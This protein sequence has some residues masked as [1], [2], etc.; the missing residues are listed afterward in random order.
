MIEQLPLFIVV[1][2]IGAFF[3]SKLL[4]EACCDPDLA[5]NPGVNMGDGFVDI[6]QNLNT[7]ATG[8]KQSDPLVFQ[9]DSQVPL[10]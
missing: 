9:V 10:C 7:T 8:A 4:R 2:K 1:L 6:G 3:A 5:T